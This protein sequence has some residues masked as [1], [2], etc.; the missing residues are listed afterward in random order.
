MPK[1]HNLLFPYTPMQQTLVTIHFKTKR[2][3]IAC[4][5]YNTES[6]L[7][8]NNVTYGERG[9]IVMEPVRSRNITIKTKLTVL[10][11][12]LLC[13]PFL[14][15][16]VLWYKQATQTINANAEQA[17]I[18]LVERLHEQ[19]DSYFSDIENLTFP[20]IVQKQIKD[21]MKTDPKDQY[22]MFLITKDI[23]SNL[24]PTVVNSRSDIYGFSIITKNG[25]VTTY[26]SFSTRE[27]NV[28]YLLNAKGDES[29]RVAGI[30][31]M[32]D[33]NM[34]AIT[35]LRY[36]HDVDTYQTLGL[37]AVDLKTNKINS[38]LSKIKLGETGSISLI[39]ADGRIVYS[40]DSD[41][42]GEPAPASYVNAD[43]QK[44]VY[45]EVDGTNKLIYTSR[46]ERTGWKLISEVPVKELSGRLT[47]LRNTTIWV[48]AALILFA[49]IVIS[50]FSF[51]LTRS[52]SHLQ[53]LMKRAESGDLTVRAP[54]KRTDE[55]GGLNRSFNKMVAEIRRLIEFVQTTK[56]R[57]KE[58]QIKQRESSLQAMQSQINPH[59]LY[60]TLEVIN[61]YAILEGV[62]PISH[63]AT[64]LADIFRYSVG[65]AR[66]TV[67][68]QEEINHIATYFSIQKERYPHLTVEL[69]V[70]V[71]N[72]ARVP[73]VR[74]M[75]QPLV[76]NVF[77]HAYEK[78]KLR[79]EYVG[80]QGIVKDDHYL[81][82]VK[83][84]GRGIDPHFAEQY[85]R[86]F[87]ESDGEEEGGG[88][89]EGF[90]RHIGMLNVH[91][92]LRLTFGMK[93]GLHISGMSPA[94]GTVIEIKLPFTSLHSPVEE[95]NPDDHGTDG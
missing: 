3:K 80:I 67:S 93:Y 44:A 45:R 84:R 94:A 17:S 51:N 77:I 22:A 48:G 20:L 92:R 26:G 73:A 27:R 14:T 52:L 19:L 71:A 8:D 63:M 46:S 69:D 57:E 23:E 53:R 7:K 40:N 1:Q 32:S 55:I 39:D 37:L 60:N 66:H 16:G 91:Q 56:L 54:E 36:F 34:N 47:D 5:C 95:E 29:F 86:L 21:F 24:L 49:M 38:M 13:I 4:P 35:V 81:V 41:K 12:G 83:D 50:G 15:F 87:A 58:M 25:T 61:S 90:Q 6:A 88:G 75:L 65:D 68:L 28:Q 11:L 30:S 2:K 85:N 33:S 72:A 9:W 70:D 31:K 78:H 59:F 42:I 62:M 79:P 89:A 64:S 43:N 10:I 82:L 74:L 76:E 18:Q